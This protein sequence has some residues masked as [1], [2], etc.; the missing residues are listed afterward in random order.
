MADVDD[1]AERHD[2]AASSTR[3]TEPA[4]ARSRRPAR[5]RSARQTAPAR[6]AQLR[7]R[8]SYRSASPRATPS[9][10][11]SA[12]AP[13]AVVERGAA[14][15]RSREAPPRRARLR[16]A[17][18][19]D[20]PARS[21]RRASPDRAAAH[22]P[23][24]TTMSMRAGSAGARSLRAPART[25]RRAPSGAAGARAAC[26][27]CAIGLAIHAL[28]SAT[29]SRAS[30]C[31]SSCATRTRGASRAAAT[32]VRAASGRV[33]QPLSSPRDARDRGVGVL[34][35]SP[36]LPRRR[37][38]A[39]RRAARRCCPGASCRVTAPLRQIGHDD[40]DRRPHLRRRCRAMTSRAE[41]RATARRSRARPTD[42]AR[43][44]S[45]AATSSGRVRATRTR[46][47]DAGEREAGHVVRCR[48]QPDLH[49]T[50]IAGS[51]GS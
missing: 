23:P 1:F 4:T 2:V 50:S 45:R 43:A 39:W 7:S 25:V 20:R 22:P 14:V 30:S 51:R 12:R 17:R 26:P 19:P 13:E 37:R 5:Q 42:R 27:A 47:L 49:G 9:A 34:L 21:G 29:A 16:C 36:P 6:P 44:A 40:D 28:A 41:R 8:R 11:R 15:G 3:T 18:G 48:R 32:R 10:S 35:E 33:G 24:D 31:Q 38:R 46:G